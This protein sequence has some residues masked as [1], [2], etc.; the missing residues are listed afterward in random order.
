MSNL[1]A[2]FDERLTSG[3]AEQAME[4][5]TIAF[6]FIGFAVALLQLV[7]VGAYVERSG[8]LAK[9]YLS[10]YLLLKDGKQ[11]NRKTQVSP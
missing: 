7:Q 8:L 4:H 11:C 10:D 1:K 9:L 3:C 6:I 5:M 2:Q